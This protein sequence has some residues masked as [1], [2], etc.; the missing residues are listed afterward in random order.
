ME[1]TNYNH[2]HDIEFMIQLM[3]ETGYSITEIEKTLGVQI[4]ARLMLVE[5]VIQVMNSHICGELEF[6]CN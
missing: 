4:R 5:E 6:N 1:D 2:E 3:L